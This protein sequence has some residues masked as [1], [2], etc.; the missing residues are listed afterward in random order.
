M[1]DAAYKYAE[2]PGVHVIDELEARD[3]TQRDLAYVLGMK[4]AQLS[5]F[6]TG[7]TKVTADLAKKL[8][9][10]FDISAEFFLNLQT[11]FDLRCAEEPDPSIAMRAK[12]QSRFPLRDMISR[13]W[14]DDQLMD[15]LDGQMDRFFGGKFDENDFANDNFEPGL[16][17][18]ARKS[19]DYRERITPQQHAWVA[20]VEQIAKCMP[21]EGYDSEQ[22]SSV[23]DF[24]QPLM[25]ET[26]EICRIPHMLLDAGV[27]TVFVE[28]LPNCK[29]D[30]VCL[31]LNDGPVIGMSLRLNRVDNFW[32]TLRHELEH[33]LREDGKDTNI[34]FAHVDEF[35]K[36]NFEGDRP[37]E[38]IEADRAALDFC[39]PQAALE[40]FI[41]RKSPY[42]SEKDVLG[43]S[44]RVGTHPGIVVGQ[45]QFRQNKWN[46]LRKYLQPIKEKALADWKYQDGWGASFDVDL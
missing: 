41:A 34:G 31:W 4:E 2:H 13:G 27:R 25:I 10:A 20:R 15:L 19:G 39:V 23:L 16:S 9:A 14:I 38:E 11:A 43:F 24:I 33:V 32:F 5:R 21:F 28:A 18:A 22:L 8:S 35:D 1:S 7:K 36:E 29:M 46:W 26:D 3:M 12:W 44:A 40:N 17:F 45:I 37:K 42:I 30:G 6:L